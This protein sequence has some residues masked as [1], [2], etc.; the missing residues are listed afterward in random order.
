MS[1]EFQSMHYR[2]QREMLDAIA[3]E[4]L[5]AGGLNSRA[6]IMGMHGTDA[7]FAEEC[8]DGW[9][10]DRRDTF[11]DESVSHL[12]RHGYTAEEL[13]EAF[14]RLRAR[15]ASGEYFAEAA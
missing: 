2:C 13:A 10:L 3:A 14:G 11:D 6:I 9:G 5:T 15:V 4:W 8:V 1:Y 7:E 12:T